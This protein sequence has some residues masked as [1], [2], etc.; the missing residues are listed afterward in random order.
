MTSD[1]TP[2]ATTSSITSSFPYLTDQTLKRFPALGL[3]EELN[4]EI[5]R[6]KAEKYKLKVLG[7]ERRQ[8]NAELKAD[9]S[10][11]KADLIST[12]L[13]M[14]ELKTENAKLKAKI[15]KLKAKIDYA[16][17]QVTDP[18]EL[19]ALLVE[20]LKAKL[21]RTESCKD[22]TQRALSLAMA[23][24]RSSRSRLT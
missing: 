1:M 20:S 22:D 6:L 19:R 4:A 17:W 7:S 14:E 15:T 8:E 2:D 9:L 18:Y 16:Q 12:A 5:D 3:I 23:L 21:E 24:I 13:D 11:L 10:D